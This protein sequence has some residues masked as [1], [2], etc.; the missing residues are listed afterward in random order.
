VLVD[1]LF[2]NSLSHSHLT[3]SK[4]K[5]LQ[6]V[7]DMILRLFEWSIGVISNQ[8]PRSLG[9]DHTDSHF[10]PELFLLFYPSF[11]FMLG[12]GIC[13]LSQ[14]THSEATATASCDYRSFWSSPDVF[15][16]LNQADISQIV[17]IKGIKFPTESFFVY[18]HQSRHLNMSSILAISP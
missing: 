3:G 9:I 13:Q 11:T 10:S 15:E 14:T 12:I 5:H 17:N 8:M 2:S 1:S 18:S 16:F 7:R 4:S 6:V